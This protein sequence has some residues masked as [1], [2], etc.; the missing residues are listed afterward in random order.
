MRLI[1]REKLTT[2]SGQDRDTA[3]WVASWSAELLGANWKRPA[4][5]VLQFPRASQKLDGIFMFQ[6]PN[7]AIEID[8]LISF[9]RGIILIVST[10]LL[11]V[12]NDH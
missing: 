8:A 2:L 11:E 12:A 3:R 4:D 7:K 9:P 5:V 6:P 1:G 10:R